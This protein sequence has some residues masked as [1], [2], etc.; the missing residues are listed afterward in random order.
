[1]TGRK[2]FGLIV[3][4]KLITHPL[5][6]G[7]NEGTE[8]QRNRGTERKIYIARRT[9]TL[10]GKMGLK[11]RWFWAWGPSANPPRRRTVI[12]TIDNC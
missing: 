4:C 6:A 2:S 1:M 11:P 3:S 10:G 12:K 7:R 9:A 8:K 5:T